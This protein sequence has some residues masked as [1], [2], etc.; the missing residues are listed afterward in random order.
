LLLGALVLAPLLLFRLVVSPYA[1]TLSTRR[2]QLHVQQSLLE[3]ELVL[4]ADVKRYAASM[5][6]SQAAAREVMP[7]LFLGPD[8]DVS[9]TAAL[10]YYVSDRARQNRVFVQQ[11]ETRPQAP[12]GSGITRVQ[13]DVRAQSDLQG[14]LSYLRALEQGPKVIQIE[15]IG[16]ER[17]QLS[18]A[19]AGDTE[20]LTLSMTVNGFAAPAK[21]IP[22]KYTIVGASPMAS[23]GALP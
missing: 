14:L 10:A 16:I 3:R 1:H 4:L 11:I 8:D 17:G 21:S 23:L 7:Q 9:T 18:L 2:E 19:E 5:R 12:A 6:Q 22:A 13:V 20:V 15:H